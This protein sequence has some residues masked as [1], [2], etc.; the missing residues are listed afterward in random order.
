MSI[1]NIEALMARYL[2]DTCKPD[3]KILFESWLQE[4]EENRQHFYET[5]Q[6]WHASK[7]EFFR[8]EEQL[9]KAQQR[10]SENLRISQ[11][12]R[13]RI[14]VRQIARYAAVLICALAITW[15]FLLLNN[16]NI[17]PGGDKSAWQTILVSQTD[18]SRL[19]VLDDGSRIWLNNNSTLSYPAR[20]SGKH[21][22]ISFT[23]EGYFE[24]A[25]DPGHPFIV[26]TNGIDI[27]VLGTSFNVNAYPESAVSEAVLLNGS[28]AIVDSS[29]KDMAF[30]KPGQLALF[31]KN[32]RKLLL[33]EVDAA[34]YS[35]WRSGQITLHDA[36]LP[37]IARKLSELYGVECSIESTRQESLRFNFTFSKTKPVS[38]VLEMLSFIA[39]VQYRIQGKHIQIS[40]K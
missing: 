34:A 1:E 13:R 37:T 19:V 14:V 29:G 23:G 24:V 8:S 11:S 30:M 38:E 17:D 21:R 39:P 28:I 18:S 36:D 4:S 22:T 6:L 15:I 26:H 40:H 25:H 20:F 31:N 27:K 16:S 7:I 32:D 9:D 2:Q 3:E 5:K 12:K 33:K 35:A 10:F